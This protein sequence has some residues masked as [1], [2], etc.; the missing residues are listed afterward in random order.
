MKVNDIIK[1]KIVDLDYIGLGIGKYDGYT[2]FTDNALI[3]ELVLCK[4][5]EVKKNI[6]FANTIKVLEKS[7]DRVDDF[8]IDG[9]LCGGCMLKHLNYDKQI[10]FKEK[11]VSDTFLKIAKEKVKVNNIFKMDNP[12]FYRNKIQVP[13]SYD[14]YGFYEY[15]THKIVNTKNCNVEPEISRDIL[16]SIK[17]FNI[18]HNYQDLRHVLIKYSKKLNQI[19]VV[20]VVY[21]IKNFKKLEQ[22]FIDSLLKFHVAT[23]ILNENSKDTNVI[24]GDKNKIIYGDGYIYDIMNDLKFKIGVES[25]YQIN[26]LQAE[27][28]YNKAIKMADI[29]SKDIVV[30]CYCGIGTITLSIA[31]KAKKVY[32]IEIVPEAIK[33]AIDNQKINNLNN[34]KFILGKSEDKIYEIL[35]N[36]KI[37]VIFVDPP[38]KGLDNKMIEALKKYKIK[39]VIYISCNVRTLARDYDYLKDLYELK[40]INAYDFFPHTPHI[41]TVVL[42]SK[43]D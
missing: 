27:K 22:D 10:L 42:L 8:C 34:V 31:K 13:F 9:K 41:E 15:N 21:N 23:I 1:L 38:R 20:L 2:I 5:T 25:F 12:Y 28:L 7:N 39:K 43:K 33:N 16:N 18:K 4:I 37:D 29:T 17:D 26:T 40:E 24:L 14:N 32:G 30:D 19:M 6:C 36:D 11:L 35:K 3:D